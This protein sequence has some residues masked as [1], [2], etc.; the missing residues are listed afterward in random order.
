MTFALTWPQPCANAPLSE[1]LTILK[2]SCCIKIIGLAQHSEEQELV[3][4]LKREWHV[5]GAVQ[6]RTH[7]WGAAQS[8]NYKLILNFLMPQWDYTRW[9]HRRVL[10]ECVCRTWSSCMHV[11]NMEQLHARDCYTRSPATEYR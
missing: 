11:H 1:T 7:M 6:H 5:L 2:G 8:Y 4:H 10:S 9:M 3:R